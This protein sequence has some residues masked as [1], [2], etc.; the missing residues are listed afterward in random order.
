[1]S[2]FNP[3]PNFI[4]DGKPA[5]WTFQFQQV[6]YKSDINLYAKW[7]DYSIEVNEVSLRELT[8]T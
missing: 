1:M 6:I 4:P 7:K 2:P 8:E 3:N 5:H